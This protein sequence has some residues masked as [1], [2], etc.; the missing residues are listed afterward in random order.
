MRGLW[1]RGLWSGLARGLWSGLA[2]THCDGGKCFN[3]RPDPHSRVLVVC[4]CE[5]EAGSVIR[6]ISARKA[7]KSERKYYTGEKS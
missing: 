1:S 3:A 2:L 5:R 4:H 7:T 6:I